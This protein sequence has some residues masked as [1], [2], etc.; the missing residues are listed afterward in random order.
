MRRDIALIVLAAWRGIPPA[1]TFSKTPQ[2]PGE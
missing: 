1:T 2:Q